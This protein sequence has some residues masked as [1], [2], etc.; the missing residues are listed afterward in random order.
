MQAGLADLSSRYRKLCQR[1]GVERP[2]LVSPTN[3]GVAHVEMRKNTYEYI[4]T[5]R[6]VEIERRQTH[7]ANELLYWLA[8]DLV[9]SIANSY[10]ISQGKVGQEWLKIALEQELLVMQKLDP[11]WRRRLE[12]ESSF[13][14]R[15]AQ[16]R[17]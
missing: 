17:E 4:V 6:G 3:D 9:S 16:S 10:A 15:L 14:R 8:C 5:E 11:E 13:Q 1:L 12:G 2:F 7:D